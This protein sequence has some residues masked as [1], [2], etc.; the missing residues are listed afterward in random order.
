[1]KHQY[2]PAVDALYIPLSTAAVVE[3]EEVRP[4]IIVDVDA[5]GR[6][7]GVEILDASTRLAP[8]ADLTG[9]AA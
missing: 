5:E 6:I 9:L 8:G 4:G 3:S 7:V 2:D 1:M